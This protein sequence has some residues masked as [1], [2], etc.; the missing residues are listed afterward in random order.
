MKSL[1]FARVSRS[2]RPPT[3]F[4]LL[5][6]AAASLLLPVAA[7]AQ[8]A[9]FNYPITTLGGGFNSPEG[10]AVDGSGNV[11]VADPSTTQ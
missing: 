11:Y 3:Q 10:V 9:S 4:S 6:L 5:L 7:R 8:T 1:V 2:S